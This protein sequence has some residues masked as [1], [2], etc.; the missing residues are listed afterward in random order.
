MGKKSRQK[1]QKKSQNQ[2]NSTNQSVKKGIPGITITPI[3]QPGAA[4][5][6]LRTETVQAVPTLSK[7]VT[8]LVPD[9]FLRRDI[10]RILLTL[11][12]LVVILAALVVVNDKTT[13]LKT[14]GHK[15]A[16]FAQL[17]S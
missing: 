7:P 12:V 1:Q 8:T 17:Q 13:V 15:L 11:G 10:R 9:Q 16:V 4:S 2:N 3:G 5:A 14:A 6:V